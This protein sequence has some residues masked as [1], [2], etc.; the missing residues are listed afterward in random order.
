MTEVDWNTYV[1]HIDTM[2]AQIK[3][4]N[5]KYDVVIGIG[6]GGLVPALYISKM[7]N[8]PMLV[9]FAQRYKDKEPSGETRMSHLT[10]LHTLQYTDMILLVD[11]IADGGVTLSDVKGVLNGLNFKSL[12]TGVVYKRSTSRIEPDYIGVLLAEDC[13]WLKFPYDRDN[14]VI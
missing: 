2:I 5:I 3:G 6:R 9:I 12:H 13:G 1:S 8:I 11:D 4:S 14:K 10:G 7:L